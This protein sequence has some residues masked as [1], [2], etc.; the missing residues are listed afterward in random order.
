M[1][2]KTTFNDFD[3]ILAFSLFN[4]YT[5][6]DILDEEKKLVVTLTAVHACIY[7]IY[8]AQV[9]RTQEN[10]YSEYNCARKYHSLGSGGTVSCHCCY[11]NILRCWS[12]IGS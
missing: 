6:Y 5:E 9:V 11:K 1:S 2:F 3:E 8:L 7:N 12:S 4:S 10:E